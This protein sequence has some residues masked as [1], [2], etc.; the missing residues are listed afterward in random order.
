MKDGKV[1]NIGTDLNP[2]SLPGAIKMN[3]YGRFVTPGIVDMHS[4]AGADSYPALWGNQD[5]NDATDPLTPYFRVLDS[6][7][8]E[9]MGLQMI[10]EGGVTTSQILPGSANIM[11]GE[12]FLI[13]HKLKGKTIESM[14]LLDAPRSLKV[15]TSCNTVPLMSGDGQRRES[16]ASV[17]S[18]PRSDALCSHGIRLSHALHLVQGPT[19]A[20]GSTA[21]V[22]ADHPPRRL[23]CRPE[24]RCPGGPA[25]G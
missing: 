5:V 15:L 20:Q 12:A 8:P 25:A 3:G 1:F 18:A 11:G 2:D 13:K 21:V 22:S 6:F 23:P 4:H 19:P 17:W 9:D 7:D 14:R 10:L 24:P 16:E